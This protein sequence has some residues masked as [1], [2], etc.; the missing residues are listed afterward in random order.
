MPGQSSG[1]GCKLPP[2]KQLDR[3]S[4]QLK[5]P[6]QKSG[7]F[8]GPRRWPA[9]ARWD[10]AKS[11]AAGLALHIASWLLGGEPGALADLPV[12]QRVR[13]ACLPVCRFNLQAAQLL[14]EAFG[15]EG[16]EPP[17]ASSQ[18]AYQLRLVA[19][20]WWQAFA[21]RERFV[22]LVVEQAGGVAGAPPA[23][24]AML[25]PNSGPQVGALSH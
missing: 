8:L 18:L 12:R 14:S 24:I 9:S 15:G 22:R 19:A 6:V 17:P 3:T 1:P 20:L 11:T 5:R 16:D 2:P 13:P 23:G 21:L 7:S 25:S 4:A 10:R